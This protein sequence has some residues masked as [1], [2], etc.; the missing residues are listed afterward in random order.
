MSEKTLSPELLSRIKDAPKNYV[1]PSW[2]M[3]F[4]RM[5]YLAASKSKDDKTKIGAVIVGPQN[6]PIS[7]GFNGMP[8]GVDDHKEERYCRPM[9]YRF[10]EH[11]ERNS[12]YT[13]PRIG[14]YLPQGS[15]M[16]TSGTPC[17]DCGR[18]IIQAGISEVIVHEPFELIS[19]Y[20]YDNWT[21]SSQATADMFAES[22]VGLRFFKEYVGMDGYINEKIISV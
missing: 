5:V 4:M 2:D 12:I 18:A 16:Y 1:P 11:A 20:L 14:A 6:E 3:L 9:K 8:R 7:F 22:E 21:E 15:K 19:L 10:F 13:L 17:C